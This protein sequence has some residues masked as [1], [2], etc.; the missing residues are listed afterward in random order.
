MFKNSNKF[1][2]RLIVLI[3]YLELSLL[4]ETILTTPGTL[5]NSGE[6]YRLNNNLSTNG[7]VFTID[8]DNIT[9]DL[10]GHIIEYNNSN[11]GSGIRVYGNNNIVKTHSWKNISICWFCRFNKILKSYIKQEKDSQT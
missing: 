3:F 2:Y 5:N 7:G 11:S 9:L 6:Y 1:L 8:G 10:N 4:G